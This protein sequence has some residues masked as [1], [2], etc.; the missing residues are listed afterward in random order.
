MNEDIVHCVDDTWETGEY[1]TKD[2][3]EDFTRAVDAEEESFVSPKTLV[4]RKGCN[5]SIF[6]FQFELMIT[7]HQVDH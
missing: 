1:F 4:R 2:V 6:G 3:V 7:L 5:L